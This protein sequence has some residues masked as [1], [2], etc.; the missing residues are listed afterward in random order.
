VRLP[1][2]IQYIREEGQDEHFAFCGLWQSLATE[3]N[4]R[5]LTSMTPARGREA[6]EAS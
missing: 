3:L 1:L 2:L 5:T 4:G 6:E